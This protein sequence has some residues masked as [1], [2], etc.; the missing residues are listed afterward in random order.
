MQRCTGNICA[1]Q[2][3]RFKYGN[4]RDDTR[5]ADAVENLQ[6]LGFLFF[7]REFI[8][9]CPLRHFCRCPHLFPLCKVIHLDY[10]AINVI[11]Q[12]GSFCSNC[13][14]GIQNFRFCCERFGCLYRFH[15]QLPQI[16][17]RLPMR[18]QRF[19]VNL[20]DVENQDVQATLCRHRGIFL[21]QRT[22]GGISWILERRFPVLF[23]LFRQRQKPL[24]R[25]INFSTH[26]QKCRSMFQVQRNRTNRFQVFGDIFPDKS[27]ATS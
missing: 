10:N 8:G 17:Q 21:P 13:L 16:V 15:T 23:L 27:I 2:P 3:N 25:H 14:Q 1:C 5:S 7:R 19:A 22:R 6:Q 18:S 24:S 9:N 4:W 26:F 12:V 11:G 20:L